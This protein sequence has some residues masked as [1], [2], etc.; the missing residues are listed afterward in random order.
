MTF[1]LF[2]SICFVFINSLLFAQLDQIKNAGIN[3][4]FIGAFGTHQQRFGIVVQG[5][6]V[7]KFAQI[8]ASVRLYDNI[9]DLGPKGEHAELA[10]AIGFCLGY[11]K[12]TDEDNLFVSSVTNQTKHKYSF[13][14]SYNFW[15]NK[16][17]TSQVAGII[18]FQFN[19]FSVICENDIFAKPQLDRFR[20]GGI[21]LQYQY[22][23][24]QFALNGNMWT[25]HLGKIFKYDTL[26]LKGFMSDV[27][28]RYYSNISHGLLSAQVKYANEYGQYLQANVGVDAEQVRNL[29]Q[30]KMIHDILPNN[31][32][33][34]MLDINGKQY[35]KQE[36][37]K[38]RKPKPYINLYTSPDVF[39]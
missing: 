24:F 17:H 38:V 31:Y 26:G 5:Y 14:Y 9:K 32:P 27:D 34:P 7:Y 6:Y 21:I 10:T 28:A 29:F 23:Q 36:G 22:K 18:A 15:Y 33:M 30:N 35:F 39:Y 25:G 19:H 37:Q 1:K 16:I 12:K 20:T 4:G 13:A 2:I 3:V 8:N 11:E